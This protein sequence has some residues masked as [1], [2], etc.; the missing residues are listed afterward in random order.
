MNH[1]LH[2]PCMHSIMSC[3]HSSLLA[4]LAVFASTRTLGCLAR[5]VCR[6]PPFIIVHLL[7]QASIRGDVGG[8]TRRASCA[9][10][11]E[12]GSEVCT[13]GGVRHQAV[14]VHLAAHARLPALVHGHAHTPGVL[15]CQPPVV[16]I[17]MTLDA[18]ERVHGD[19]VHRF[20]G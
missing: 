1:I 12:Q 9:S 10:G 4:T 2:H 19:S 15:A 13:Q 17:L 3:L 6:C 14:A 5:A 20:S 18:C 11:C 7:S 16:P 8:G